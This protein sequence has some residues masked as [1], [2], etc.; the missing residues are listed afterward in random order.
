MQG[1]Y[2]PQPRL[3]LHDPLVLGGQVG[4]GVGLIARV[5]AART[6]LPFSDVDRMVE[7]SEGRALAR[8]LAED[9]PEVLRERALTNLRRALGRQPN[10]VIVLGSPALL[11]SD[12]AWLREHARFV[13]VRRSPAALLQR[14][15]VEHAERDRAR[16]PFQF[17]LPQCEAELQPLLDAREPALGEAAVVIDAGE[18]HPNAVARDLLDSLDRIMGVERI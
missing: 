18:R 7:G 12:G 6:G 1:Y 2:D 5:I 14:I 9:G 10:G 3:L 8:I 15:Q 4:A 13:Y 16:F 11:Q 17:G